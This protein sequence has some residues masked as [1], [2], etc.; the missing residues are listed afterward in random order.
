MSHS[1]RG[2]NRQQGH[3]H[4]SPDNDK[5]QSTMGG[6]YQFIYYVQLNIYII[7]V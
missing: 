6:M 7:T 3:G 2:L 4:M 5:K 1:L